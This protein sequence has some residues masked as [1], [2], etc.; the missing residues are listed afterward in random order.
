MREVLTAATVK[1][2]ASAAVTAAIPAEYS[3]FC[4]AC[5]STHGHLPVS[6]IRAPWASQAKG[7]EQ[8]SHSIEQ[9][10]PLHRA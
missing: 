8:F 5:G 6:V 10:S 7:C 4:G 3:G 1:G 9:R 2:A